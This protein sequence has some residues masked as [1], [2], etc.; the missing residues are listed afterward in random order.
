[1]ISKAVNL[2]EEPDAENLHVRFREG[3]ALQAHGRQRSAMA[4]LIKAKPA[5]RYRVLRGER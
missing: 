2:F 4:V 1:M 3:C 5:V